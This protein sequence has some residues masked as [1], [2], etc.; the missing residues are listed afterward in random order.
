M[1]SVDRTFCQFGSLDNF[2]P[3]KYQHHLNYNQKEG[4]GKFPQQFVL[5]EQVCDLHPECF[6]IGILCSTRSDSGTPRS[7]RKAKGEVLVL[8][9]IAG[10]FS[11]FGGSGGSFS[12]SSSAI[13]M[14][15]TSLPRNTM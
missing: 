8:T 3:F 12:F 11:T 7:E 5:S 14:S 4:N 10:S 2:M 9:T 13:L 6:I 15:L 1:H